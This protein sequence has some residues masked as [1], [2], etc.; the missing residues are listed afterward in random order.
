MGDITY[1]IHRVEDVTEFV[2]LKQIG[3]EQ[4]RITQELHTRTGNME[5]EIFRRAQDIQEVNS[6]LQ[7]ELDARQQAQQD[8]EQFFALS[9]DMLC[10]AKSDGYFKR[11]SP[12]FTS[13][14]GWSTDE[15]LTRPFLDF[16][17]PDDRAA[18]LGEVERQMARG[19]QVLQFD[20][21]YG[22]KD[23]S[24]RVFVMEIRASTGWA[25]VCHRSRYHGEQRG[26]DS[27]S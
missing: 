8:I 15:M 11:V 5:A 9:L 19:E 23:G 24:W 27:A 2:R 3:N 21:R 6:R 18:T 14:L 16:V 26:R 25:H 13:A 1:I 7:T 17:H 22:P 12:A 4:Q 20:N 10:I